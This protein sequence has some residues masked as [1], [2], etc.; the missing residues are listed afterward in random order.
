VFTPSVF[1]PIVCS[2]K[3]I[4]AAV[5]WYSQEQEPN[6]ESVVWASLV[7]PPETVCRPIYMTSLT[8]L[9]STRGWAIAER[10][11]RYSVS[12]E[13]LSYC[14]MNNADSVSAFA[15]LPATTATCMVLY[16]RIVAIGS[17]IAKWAWDAPLS[18][19]RNAE[20]GR[21]INRLRR[22]PTLLM[23]PYSVLLRRT[24]VDADHRGG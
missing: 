8:L 22:R 20:V 17:A 1:I 3:Q 4:Q 5:D 6:T 2:G 10:P 21:V 18:H 13:M 9:H 16:T 19:I 7:Q 23:T 24:V 14:C 12:V 11:A 15:S